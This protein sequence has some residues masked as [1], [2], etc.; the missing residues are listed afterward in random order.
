MGA[1]FILITFLACVFGNILPC[2]KFCKEKVKPAPKRWCGLFW[3]NGLILILSLM[4][5]PLCIY[6]TEGIK[7]II[8]DPNSLV[9]E[10]RRDYTDFDWYN[11]NV[12]ASLSLTFFLFCLPNIFYCILKKYSKQDRL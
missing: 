1:L 6:A 5:L 2:V 3:F 10:M 12:I 8:M 9:L 7:Q 4:Y 11:H